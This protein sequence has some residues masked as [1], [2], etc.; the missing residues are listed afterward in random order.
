MPI[1]VFVRVFTDPQGGL[2]GSL[3]WGMSIATMARWRMQEDA[4]LTVLSANALIEPLKSCVV[5]PP[6]NFHIESKRE[7]ERRA[8]TDIYIVSDDDCLPIGRD[9]IES[10]V[11]ALEARPNYGLVGASSICDGMFPAGCA[12][13]SERIYETHSAGGIAFVRRGVI[14]PEKLPDCEEDQVDAVVC[15]HVQKRGFKVGLLP[16]VL[17]N[18]LGCGYSVTSKGT[19]NWQA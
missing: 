4:N 6:E 2:K 19:G 7:A 10:G 5:M 16:Q 1:D 12:R 8:T 11:E 15:A 13:P 17:F 3:R 9:F 14:D 18:H